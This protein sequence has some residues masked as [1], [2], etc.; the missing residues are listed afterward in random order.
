MLI[1]PGGRVLV[2]TAQTPFIR[3]GSEI[4]A[5]SLAHELS[6]RGWVVDVIRIP[7]R[8]NPKEEILKSY[9]MW[10]LIDLT[11][12]DGQPIDLVIATRFPS[13][14]ACHPNKVTWLVQQFRQ[15]YDLFG[16]PNSHFTDSPEDTRLRQLI[17]QADIHTLTEAKRLFAISKNVAKRLYQYNGLQAIPLY[18]PPQHEGKYRN[19]GYGDYVLSVSRLNRFKRV[20]LIIEAMA[21]VH[22]RMRLFIASEGPERENLQK[23]AHRRGVSDRVKFLGYVD[24]DQLLELYANCFAVFYGPLDEDYGLA[25]VEA[26]KSQKPVLTASDSGGV[27]EFVEDE[28]NGYVV[29]PDQPR[30]LAERLDQLYQ[31]PTL[32]QQ[33]G[34]AGFEQ[35]R[36]ITWEST[37]SHLLGDS[38]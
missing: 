22:P 11:E 24:D 15:A 35:V 23:L 34:I 9:M 29:S 7:F 19:D 6:K 13:F 28:V 36:P 32:C 8:W 20:N 3:G 25:T 12:A 5:D 38:P 18:P 26:F 31:T 30:Q 16:T 21:Y 17:R 2:C 10:R 37:L 27:L 4:L 14:A 33:L 1:A